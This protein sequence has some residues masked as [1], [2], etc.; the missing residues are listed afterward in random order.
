VSRETEEREEYPKRGR[1]DTSTPRT[2]MCTSFF[3]RFFCSR[4]IGRSEQ[5]WNSYGHCSKSGTQR[6]HV[7]KE[8][9]E[10]RRREE[11]TSGARSRFTTYS[12]INRD[13]S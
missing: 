8:K 11:R 5:K 3:S 2:E 1:R 13:G 12:S 6:V 9:G 10:V 4:A 7:R